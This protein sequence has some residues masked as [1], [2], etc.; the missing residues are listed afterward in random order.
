[1]SKTYRWGILGT[2]NAASV[3][4]EAITESQ[5]GSLFAIAS[6]SFAKAEE[7][8]LKYGVQKYYGSY[9]E[10]LGDPD[11]DIVCIALPHNLHAEWSIKAA[12]AKKH[13]LCEKPAAITYEATLAV[14]EEVRKQDVFYME[15]YMYRCHPQTL[16][17]LEILREGQIGSIRLIEASFCYHAN[18][19][20]ANAR[21]NQRR[22]GGILDV[23]GYPVSIAR[24][25]AGAQYDD[26]GIVPL[27]IQGIAHIGEHY[28]EW[29]VANLRFSGDILAQVSA[30]VYL[31]HR[32][33][34]RIF[35]SKGSIYIPSPWVPGGRAPGITSIFLKK[36]GIKEIEEIKI[37][38]TCSLY[39]YEVD[40]VAGAL[41]KRCAEEINLNDTLGNALT[42]E[43]WRK[44]AGIDLIHDSYF[45]IPSFRR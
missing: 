25:I 45:D 9:E 13:I 5:T 40:V 12:Q 41:D 39:S 23:G 16:R 6:R 35:G 11:V 44:S 34:V 36:T 43:L 31:E 3:L 8:S 17:L 28:D 27:E 32:N 21:A 7:F 10:L 29:A 22:G 19:S 18:F 24:L 37:N 26:A 42:I 14:V 38:S 30:A 33:D 20:R 15:G 1:M 2:G 4:A